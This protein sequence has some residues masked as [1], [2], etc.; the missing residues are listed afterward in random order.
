MM[1]EGMGYIF[2]CYIPIKYLHVSKSLLPTLFS[3]TLTHF[4]PKKS[5]QK[6]TLIT[7]K[8]NTSVAYILHKGKEI[9]CNNIIIYC[10]PGTIS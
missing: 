6:I 3:L 8:Y 2:I 4:S 5:F 10:D 1:P 7:G 9:P